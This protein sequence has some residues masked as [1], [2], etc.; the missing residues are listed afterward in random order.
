MPRADVRVPRLS[1]SHLL[2]WIGC[3][4]GNAGGTLRPRKG[5]NLLDHPVRLYALDYRYR[6]ESDRLPLHGAEPIDLAAGVETTLEYILRVAPDAPVGAFELNARAVLY[7]AAAGSTLN[8]G[9]SP[10]AR[11]WLTKGKRA[12]ARRKRNARRSFQR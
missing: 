10:P 6:P 11:R 5:V 9:L 4:P 2:H 1:Y 12:R 8:A 7:D 3:G